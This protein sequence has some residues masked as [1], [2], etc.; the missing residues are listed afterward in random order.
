AQADK[1]II[2]C[3]L[4]RSNGIFADI[5]AQNSGIT[6]FADL[7]EQMVNT[8]VVKTHAID[9]RL[10]FGYAKQARAGITRLRPGRHSS[11]FDKAETQAAKRIKIIAVFIQPCGQTDRI[12]EAQ[13]H[14]FYRIRSH[15][16]CKYTEHLQTFGSAEHFQA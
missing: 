7:R 6:A 11:Y 13:S 2:D 12:A 4:Y 10:L 14:D 16:R 1:I 5:N 9:N 15:L 8:F 3:I